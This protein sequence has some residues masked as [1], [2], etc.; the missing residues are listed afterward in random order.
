MPGRSAAEAL[1][2]VPLTGRAAGGIRW[3]GP[4]RWILENAYESEAIPAQM[5]AF[6]RANGTIDMEGG[7]VMSG[8]ATVFDVA[9]YILSKP[10]FNGITTMK[11]QKLC[12]YAQSW[13]VAL[14]SE[15][16]FPQ[17]FQ[18]WANGP[19]CYPL[20]QSHRGQFTVRASD[21]QVGDTSRLS[22]EARSVIDEV[23]AAYGG[24]TG[25]ELSQLTHSEA[26]WK[27]ARGDLPAGATCTEVITAAS[28]GE[29][30]VQVMAATT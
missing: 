8:N 9:K 23:L 19:V 22:M 14:R 30:C 13:H 15:R 4:H 18:A 11:L 26:P 6:D 16:L 12:F 27:S 5:G 1:R 21:I 10:G 7:T 17:D 20:F 28:M 3:P 29:H 24:L 25:S 2:D